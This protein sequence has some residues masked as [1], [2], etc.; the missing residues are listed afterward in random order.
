[1][2]N[3]ADKLDSDMEIH[4][5]NVVNNHNDPAY[6]PIPFK[7]KTTQTPHYV[8]QCRYDYALLK[9]SAEPVNISGKS[10]NDI[11]SATQKLIIGTMN[12]WDPQAYITYAL[13]GHIE[14]TEIGINMVN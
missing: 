13:N 12:L 3:A 14:L 4:A 11:D 7:G 5:S 2:L 9:W 10:W 8:E 6:K 1:M